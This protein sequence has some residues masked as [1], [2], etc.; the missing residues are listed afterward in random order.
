MATNVA[1]LASGSGSNF[2]NIVQSDLD[3]SI[4]VLIVDN[5]HAY[6]IE[7]AK[8]LDVPYRI[9]DR[10]QHT[11]DS[12]EKEILTILKEYEVELI[13]LAGFMKIL[14]PDFISKYEDKIINLHP[15][16]LP[17]FKGREGI[18]DAF[19]YGVKVTGVT[20]HYVDSGIDTGMIIAQ[21]A[22]IIE[23]KD[24]LETLEEKIHEVEYRLYIEALKMV[25]E[26]RQ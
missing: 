20:V 14:S 4:K 25:L 17:S 6:A 10:K 5:P 23:D 24:T 3:I 13:V 12:F 9:V 26:E 21:E 16:L 2:Q 22:V 11:K 7:R 19:E 15:S 1:I 8:N 18:K